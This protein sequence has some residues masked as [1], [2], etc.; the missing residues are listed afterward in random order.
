MAVTGQPAACYAAF[1][2]LLIS[3]IPTPPFFDKLLLFTTTQKNILYIY[4]T[5]VLYKNKI[6]N[7]SEKQVHSWLPRRWE[8]Y[9]MLVA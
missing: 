3:N 2:M 8:T 1:I 6:I 9:L 7:G 5:I 4:Y